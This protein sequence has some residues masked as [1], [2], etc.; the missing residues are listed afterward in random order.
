MSQTSQFYAYNHDEINISHTRF[1]QEDIPRGLQLENQHQNHPYYYYP[2]TSPH[3]HPS[4]PKHPH[5]NMQPHP[6]PSITPHNHQMTD[7]LRPPRPSL[8][9]HTYVRLK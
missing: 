7:C 5:H 4:T 3:P 6:Y 1:T 9:L 2:I 8:R